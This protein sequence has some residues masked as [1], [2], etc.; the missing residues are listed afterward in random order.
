[1]D[2]E[3]SLRA[4]AQYIRNIFYPNVTYNF[5]AMSIDFHL[6]WKNI[7]ASFFDQNYNVPPGAWVTQNGVDRNLR[8]PP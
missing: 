1:M 2:Q 8:G 7:F 3:D 5:D 4:D 6:A